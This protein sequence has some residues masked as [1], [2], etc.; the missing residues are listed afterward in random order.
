MRSTVE[1]RGEERRGE[2]RRGEER[3]G[4]ERRGARVG[5][6]ESSARPSEDNDGVFQRGAFLPPLRKTNWSN[7]LSVLHA[8][9]LAF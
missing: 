4:E 3:R 2:E 8:L 1:R 6:T 9:H 5:H 7:S